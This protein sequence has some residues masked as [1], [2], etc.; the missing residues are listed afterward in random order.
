MASVQQLEF[1]ARQIT[2]GWIARSLRVIIADVS[3]ECCGSGISL[4]VAEGRIELMYRDY[5]AKE[6]LNGV[7]HTSERT[8]LEYLA[9][10][11]KEM[12]LYIDSLLIFQEETA[13]QQVQVQL[14]GSV[15]RPAFAISYHQ[16]RYL[17]E[18]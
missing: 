16:L 3:V 7:L 11:Y 10:A 4:E 2:N 17:F 9:E 6:C 1:F 8:V 12:C 15:G 18:S 14:A 13:S 5:L